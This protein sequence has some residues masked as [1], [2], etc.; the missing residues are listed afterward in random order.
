MAFMCHPGEGQSH[1]S[2]VDRMY[3]LVHLPN[4]GGPSIYR[5]EGPSTRG[6]P[7][8]GVAY[9]TLETRVT[10]LLL[11]MHASER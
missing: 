9:D 10:G 8:G 6:A 2:L 5:G 7:K 11:I 1:A 4:R 3:Q